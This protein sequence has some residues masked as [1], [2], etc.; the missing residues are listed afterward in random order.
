MLGGEE[1]EDVEE[2]VKAGGGFLHSGE[3]LHIFHREKKLVKKNE[4]VT[5]ETGGKAEKVGL[6][7]KEQDSV[8]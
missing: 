8:F 3:H 2:A 1:K 7:K 6:D 5:W 4:W